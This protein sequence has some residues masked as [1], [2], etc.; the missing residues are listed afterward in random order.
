MLSNYLE[1]YSFFF[2]C[3]NVS[4]QLLN[5]VSCYSIVVGIRYF[6][7]FP[8]FLFFHVNVAATTATADG[9]VTVKAGIPIH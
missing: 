5:M 1:I 3:S 2:V 4:F 8:L 7:L 6:S 9:V